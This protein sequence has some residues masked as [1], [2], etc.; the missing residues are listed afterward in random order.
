[1]LEALG[2]DFEP[3]VQ[4][5]PEDLLQIQAFRP[6]DFGILGRDQARQVDGEVDLQRR[7]L[8]E[9]RHDHLLVG[10]LLHFDRDADVLR[11]QVLHVEQLRQL[12]ADHDV[13]DLLDQLRLV[14]HVRHAVDVDRLRRSRLGPDV[15]RAAQADRARARFVNG[16]ELLL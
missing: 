14:H 3:E 1:M 12:A 2:D 16:F 5:V 4:E 10:V 6:A 11:R 7:V 8:E 9:V 13:R 15:P